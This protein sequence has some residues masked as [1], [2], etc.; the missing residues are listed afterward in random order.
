MTRL[1]A[2]LGRIVGLAAVLY[3]VVVLGSGIMNAYV[4]WARMLVVGAG[5]LAT[6]GGILFLFGLDRIS[7]EKARTAR[8]WGWGMFTV[9]F[10]LPTSLLFVLLAGSVLAFPAIRLRPEPAA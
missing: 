3:G 1:A 2:P 4:T 10:M 7:G 6:A 9:A 8:A 5:V